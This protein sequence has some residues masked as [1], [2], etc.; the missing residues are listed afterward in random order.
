M[1]WTSCAALLFLTLCHP[2]AAAPHADRLVAMVEK[3]P[4]MESELQERFSINRLTQPQQY[5]GVSYDQARSHVM[6]E[7][8]RDKMNA[9]LWER[10]RLN[11]L[12]TNPEQV[13]AYKNHYHLDHLSDKSVENF[14]AARLRENELSR[15]MVQRS[16]QLSDMEVEAFSR[17]KSAWQALGAQWTFRL[18]YFNSKPTEEP[19]NYKRFEQ[20]SIN[21]V[22]Q[23]IIRQIDWKKT[24]QWQYFRDDDEYGAFYLEEVFV[25]TVLQNEYNIELMVFQAEQSDHSDEQPVALTLMRTIP[26]TVT[27]ATDLSPALWEALLEL[28]PGEKSQQIPVASQWYQIKL[29]DCHERPETHEQLIS[30]EFKELLKQKKTEEK[31]PAWYSEMKKNFYIQVLE[32]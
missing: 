16:I 23:A 5:S 2:L 30:M 6:E 25:P 9:A 19:Q 14:Y 12:Q 29:N 22:Q 21:N 13:Q 27:A 18:A 17:Q 1:R 32:P 24:G 31:M 3:T 11:P 20:V 26:L 4:I 15:V 7:L 10:L 28:S 8:C